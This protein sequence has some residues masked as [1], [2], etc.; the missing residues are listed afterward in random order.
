MLGRE[1]VAASEAGTYQGKTCT[2]DL[3][4]LSDLLGIVEIVIGKSG[5]TAPVPPRTGALPAGRLE[6]LRVFLS[7]LDRELPQVIAEALSEAADAVS[8]DVAMLLEVQANELFIAYSTDPTLLE[9]R[10]GWIRSVQPSP[11]RIARRTLDQLDL[12]NALITP[13]QLGNREWMLLL[14]CQRG[15]LD[16]ERFDE[17]EPA[18]AEVF[19]N[20]LRKRDAE[21]TRQSYVDHLTG[22][23]DRW[24]TMGRIAE[25]MVSANRHQQRAAMLFIDVNGFKNVN[26]TLGHAHGDKVLHAISGCM[27]DVLRSNEFVGR[28]GGDE[29]AVVLS[30]VKNIDEA[31]RVAQRL[32]D[33]VQ[34]VR[35]ES[36][37]C[38]IT[39]GIGIAM[40]PDHA[41]DQEQWLHNADIAMYRAK[42]LKQAY[43]IYDPSHQSEAPPSVAVT[44]VTDP[45]AAYE[46]QFLL[47]FQPI[48]DVQ[49]GRATAVE[50]LVRWLHPEDGLL[51]AAST[52]KAASERPKT[53]SLDLWVARKALSYAAQWKHRGIE[54]V[55]VNIGDYSEETVAGLMRTL[56]TGAGDPSLLALEFGNAQ[57]ETDTESYARV[58]ETLA[59]T[60]AK[61]GIDDF[62]G[63]N[64]NLALLERLAIRFVKLSKTLLP[65][66]GVSGKGVESIVA[67]AR[68]LELDVI[69]TRIATSDDR[70]LI[71]NAGVQYMQGFA[72]AQPMTAIDF[73][74]W[75]S[76]SPELTLAG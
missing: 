4:L 30:P 17:I 70:R 66:T 55:H 12:S 16:Q 32:Y 31:T 1:S 72:F 35:I 21:A 61:I 65:S 20:L 43:C 49:S 74:A 15:D 56:S 75:V 36:M 23:P 71:R 19:K 2:K 29:F 68:V 52:I 9:K 50:A 41:T 39:L 11:A 26:D 54:R 46:Q 28:I 40:Y 64:V 33:E 6:S 3:G 67:L 34:N 51:S 58:I 14:G 63:G 13:L 25:A 57:P 62:G 44:S 27:R 24:A 76:G 7:Q 45:D 38:P 53:K 8:A 37:D 5:E 42:R 60:G 18:L 22:L 48:F 73:D 10:V 47:C 59:R 69:A